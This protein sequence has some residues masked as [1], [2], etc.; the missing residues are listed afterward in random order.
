M[1]EDKQRQLGRTPEIDSAQLT[2]EQ[3]AGMRIAQVL[4]WM[5]GGAII[6]YALIC[7]EH[8]CNRSR[9]PALPGATAI[10]ASALRTLHAP[11]YTTAAAVTPLD[12]AFSNLQFVLNILLPVFTTVLGYIFGTRSRG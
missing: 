10:Q 1:M 9:A 4:L 2:A 6:L 7:L 3:K 8:G 11:C 12:F 5:I